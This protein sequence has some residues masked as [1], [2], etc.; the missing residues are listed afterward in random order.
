MGCA[1]RSAATPDESI[2]YKSIKQSASPRRQIAWQLAR[3]EKQLPAA[4]P[5]HPRRR[6]LQPDRIAI[7]DSKHAEQCGERITDQGRVEVRQM[8]RADDNEC[9]Q[10]RGCDRS[11]RRGDGYLASHLFTLRIEE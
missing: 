7:R 3:I 5:I 11:G 4:L 8:S 10:N 6:T 1:T 9:R 2:D